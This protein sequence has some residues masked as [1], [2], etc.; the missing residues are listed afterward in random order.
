MIDEIK[1]YFYNL[2]SNDGVLGSNDKVGSLEKFIQPLFSPYSPYHL[3]HKYTFQR[4]HGYCETVIDKD[5]DYLF[6]LDGCRYDK[7]NEINWIDGELKSMISAGSHSEEFSINNF[8]SKNLYDTI[9]VTANAHGARI[10]EGNFHDIIFTEKN[11]DDSWATRNGMHPKNVTESAITAYDTFPN[12]RIIVHFMQP[13][14]PYFG[15][16]AN[17]IREKL[18]EKGV[19]SLGSSQWETGPNLKLAVKKGL[20]K[21]SELLE[22]YE[23]NLRFVLRYVEELSEKME[24]KKVVTADHG[25]LL[26]ER[27]GLWKYSDFSR[28]TPDRTPVGHPKNVYIEE[29]RK[30]PYLII[31]SGERSEISSETPKKRNSIDEDVIEKR[32]VELGYK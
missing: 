15:K 18:S 16:K 10:G 17:Y 3:V 14:S 22:V 29:V 11:D 26:G 6:I 13:H 7:F 25:E 24:G 2:T 27:D 30:V 1:K 5:W 32:L 23:E 28:Q 21:A 31:D 9:Y 20:I 12:K 19:D 4:K 8:K